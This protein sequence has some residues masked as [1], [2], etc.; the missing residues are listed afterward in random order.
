MEFSSCHTEINAKCDPLETALRCGGHMEGG[1]SH[2]PQLITAGAM[3]LTQLNGT[4]RL[5]VSTT[6]SALGSELQ[7]GS[8]AKV[9]TWKVP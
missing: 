2:Q 1:D 5:W 8:H 9:G 4:H 7:V 6:A 3:P